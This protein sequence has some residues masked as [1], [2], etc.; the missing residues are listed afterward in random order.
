MLQWG[1]VDED[2]EGSRAISDQRTAIR[3]QWGHVDEDV[4]EATVVTK[5]IMLGLL[6]WGHVDEDVEELRPSG[7]EDATD[8]A[9][10]G[11]RR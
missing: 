8:R 11:P 9:S 2:V 10:I 5:T 7:V 6:Q 3:L 1:H 4:E